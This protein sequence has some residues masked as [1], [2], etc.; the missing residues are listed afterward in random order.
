MVSWVMG[1][2]R[3]I[4]CGDQLMVSSS[5]LFVTLHARLSIRQVA[6]HELGE[7]L[8]RKSGVARAVVADDRLGVEQGIQ[9]RLLGGLGD[10]AEERI[11]AGALLSEHPKPG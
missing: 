9:D 1:R 7:P 8:D 11:E 5:S 3:S 4:S 2:V 10:R 6:S